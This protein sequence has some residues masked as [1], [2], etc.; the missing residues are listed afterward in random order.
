GQ[1]RSARSHRRVESMATWILPS[2]TT[3][4]KAF[5]LTSTDLVTMLRN[6]KYEYAP[7]TTQSR[8][9]RPK[10]S[11]NLRAMGRLRYTDM[12]QTLSRRSTTRAALHPHRRT[13]LHRPD[14]SSHRQFAW[15]L[16]TLRPAMG[17]PPAKPAK[18][19]SSKSIAVSR[20]PGET[21]NRYSSCAIPTRKQQGFL[22]S[23]SVP[24]PGR[25]FSNAMCLL[26]LIFLVLP[27][28]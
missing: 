25:G 27:V 15:K 4:G 13:N 22:M 5:W 6:V 19:G 24:A 17:L 18:F 16:E 28:L 7:R 3:E 9:T 26:V 12:T 21:L 20:L 11:V 1:S 23:S 2:S 14:N 10:A 8:Q